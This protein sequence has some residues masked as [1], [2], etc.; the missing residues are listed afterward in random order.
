MSHLLEYISSKT[1]E[2][3]QYIFT[4]CFIKGYKLEML[5][6]MLK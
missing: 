2:V 5:Y 4:F 3:E 6:A 1:K